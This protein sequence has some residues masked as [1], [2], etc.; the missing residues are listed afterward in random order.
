MPYPATGLPNRTTRWTAALIGRYYERFADHPVAIARQVATWPPVGCWWGIDPSHQ[1][2]VV[3][4]ENTTRVTAVHRQ[5]PTPCL[6]PGLRGGADQRCGFSRNTR[7]TL[8]T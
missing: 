5:L 1:D 8:V 3:G 2:T 6:L 7:T 4:T